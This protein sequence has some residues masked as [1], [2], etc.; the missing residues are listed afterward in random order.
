MWDDY[1]TST[2]FEARLLTLT[3]K[4]VDAPYDAPIS[5]LMIKNLTTGKM[6]FQ[7]EIDFRPLRM[8]PESL[9]ENTQALVTE[10][11]GGTA[12]GIMIFSVNPSGARLVLDEGYRVGV[13]FI[14]SNS[15]NVDVFITSGCCGDG[16]FFT[17][18][19][20]FD[21]HSYKPKGSM[22]YGDFVNILSSGFAT[23]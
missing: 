22:A 14:C 13:S 2:R 5:R 16:P 15:S 4:L 11:V 23:H 19:Y 9:F 18:R 21:G 3:P 12:N 17:T 6:I 1:K 7:Q 10:W 8:H 20:V